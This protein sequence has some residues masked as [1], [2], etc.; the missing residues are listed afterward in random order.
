MKC[1]LDSGAKTEWL[2][3]HALEATDCCDN[4]SQFM[5]DPFSDVPS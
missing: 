2:V 4:I 5:Q 3:L 1:L